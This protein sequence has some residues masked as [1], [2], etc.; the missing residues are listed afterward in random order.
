[1]NASSDTIEKLI[2]YMYT[3]IYGRDAL[4]RD[5]REKQC[6]DLCTGVDMFRVATIYGMPELKRF[7]LYVMGRTF[8]Y[9]FRQDQIVAIYNAWMTREDNSELRDC[10]LA[11]EFDAMKTAGFTMNDWLRQTEM[12]YRHEGFKKRLRRLAADWHYPLY[13]A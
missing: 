4:A 1:M 2:D 9:A 7:V 8:R 13:R 3:G 6:P 12:T 5:W 11:W 10:L